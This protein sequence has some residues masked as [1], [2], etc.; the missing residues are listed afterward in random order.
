MPGSNPT[1]PLPDRP[2]EHPNPPTPPNPPVPDPVPE[3][4]PEEE[5]G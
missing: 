5:E 3:P 2:I 1:L 4:D